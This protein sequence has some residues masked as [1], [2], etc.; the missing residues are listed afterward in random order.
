MREDI[1]ALMAMTQSHRVLGDAAGTVRDMIAAI[2][3][4]INAQLAAILRHADFQ[5]LENAWARAALFVSRTDLAR[6]DPARM[7]AELSPP[8]AAV[9]REA[10]QPDARARALLRG[11]DIA[12]ADLRDAGGAFDLPQVRA[13]LHGV[14]RQRIDK[15][16][17]DGSLL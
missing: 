5:R 14:S 7:L 1:A 3:A 9:A 15:Q 2:D 11:Q 10:F 6:V 16:V 13:V 17:R 4:K 8:A 12:A